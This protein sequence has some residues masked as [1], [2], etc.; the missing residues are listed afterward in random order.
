[1]ITRA[2][3]YRD[4][5]KVLPHGNTFLL[6]CRIVSDKVF[7]RGNSV[8]SFLMQNRAAVIEA[9]KVLTISTVMIPF[10]QPVVQTVS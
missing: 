4:R 10:A 6:K 7:L 3:L 8:V 9:R 5:R 2:R 1:M